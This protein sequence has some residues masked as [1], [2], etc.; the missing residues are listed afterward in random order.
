MGYVNGLKDQYFSRKETSK[1]IRIHPQEGNLKPM[2]AKRYTFGMYF[3]MEPK[4]YG[5]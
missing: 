4:H 2:D 1:D 3:T 5:Q